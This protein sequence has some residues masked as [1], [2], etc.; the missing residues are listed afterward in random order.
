MTI[1]PDSKKEF[2]RQASIFPRDIA[3]A[4]FKQPNPIDIG[5]EIVEDFESHV[6]SSSSSEKSVN[7]ELEKTNIR[8]SSQE[9]IELSK[10]DGPIFET[11]KNRVN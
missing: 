9:N 3:R 1:N 6:F 4:S 2:M 5:P 8:D 7:K 11:R 10:L